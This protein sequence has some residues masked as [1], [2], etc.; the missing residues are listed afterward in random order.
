MYDIKTIQPYNIYPKTY[1]VNFQ[2]VVK[3]IWGLFSR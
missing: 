2:L 3:I 1:I